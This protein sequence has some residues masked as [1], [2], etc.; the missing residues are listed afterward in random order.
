VALKNDGTMVAWGDNN[1]GQTTIPAGLSGVIAIAA[2]LGH[3]VAV[4]ND[5]TV[6]AWGYNSDDQTIIPPGLSGV[7]AIAAGGSHNV[8]L[9]N[10]GTVVAWG[11]NNWGQTTI[12][13]DLSGVTAIAAGGDH[14]VALKNDG[15]VVAWGDD[16]WSQTSIPAGLSGVTGIAA[17]SNYTLALVNLGP[18]TYSD[19]ISWYLPLASSN[20]RLPGADADGDGLSNLMEYATGTNPAGWS[21]GP[22]VFINNDRLAM[23]YTVYLLTDPPVRVTPQLSPNT[24]NWLEGTAYLKDTILEKTDFMEVHEVETVEG[25]GAGGKNFLRLKVS[26]P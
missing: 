19:W 26:T 4:K 21:D 18:V 1:W 8:A 5:G 9:K 20:D 16:Y 23:R 6:L 10:N 11:N 3:T 22:E 25:L 7:T 17:G 12:P 15:T 14:S 24:T 2:G 13:A